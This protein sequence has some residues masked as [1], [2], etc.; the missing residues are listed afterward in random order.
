MLDTWM[1]WLSI[2]IGINHYLLDP[3]INKPVFVEGS[4]G[5]WNA[6][7]YRSL[8]PPHRAGIVIN[9]KGFIYQLGG[10]GFKHLLFSPLPGEMIQFD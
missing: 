10:G 6:T 2:G 9:P 4:K 8:E 1:L 5:F 7:H 3:V